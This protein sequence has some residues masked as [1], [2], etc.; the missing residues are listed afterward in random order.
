M[1]VRSL[2]AGKYRWLLTICVAEMGTMLVFLNYSAVLPLLQ[3]E[4]HLSST[5]AGLVYSAYQ[6]GYIA[7]VAVL[8]ALTD[9]VGPKRIYV[10]SALWAGLANLL[11]PFY[12]SGL[13]SAAILRTLTGFGLAGTYMP[14]LRLVSEKFAT[15]RRGRAVGLYVAAFGLGGTLSLL[16]TGLI[17]SL[18]SWRSAFVV[19][20]FGPLAGGAIAF[21]LLEGE[22]EARGGTPRTKMAGVKENIFGNQSALLMILGYAAHMWELYGMRGWLPAFLTSSLVRSGQ[23]LVAAT[24]FGASLSAAVTVAGAVSTALAGYLSDRFGRVRTIVS[25]MLASSLCTSLLGWAWPLPL[26][27]VVALSLVSSFLATADSSVLSTSVTELVPRESLGAA[28]ALQ[29][30]LGFGTASI[31]SLVFG[32]VL[33]STNDPAALTTLGYL[34]QWGWAFSVLGLGAL[35]GPLTMFYLRRETLS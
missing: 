26:T 5:G 29:S 18:A 31:S 8:S 24:G 23:G 15:E 28:Q 33:D 35:V 7:L 22:S 32:Y 27:L 19:T 14:G 9:Y 4:W 13:A 6:I 11:F 16:L 1:R 12:A 17:A 3:R 34:P 20:S 30:F 2:E 25:L 21:A 10:G